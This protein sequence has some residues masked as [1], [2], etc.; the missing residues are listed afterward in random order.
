MAVVSTVYGI[1]MDESYEAHEWLARH[2]EE[3]E[4]FAGKWIAISPTG[5]V[6]SAA[7]LKELASQKAVDLKKMLVMRIPTVE[8]LNAVWSL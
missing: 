1:K 6:A 3:V 8:Q 5:V 4:K 7:S 2:W